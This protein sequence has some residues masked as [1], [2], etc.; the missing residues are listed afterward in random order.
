[1]TLPIDPLRTML[2]R[3]LE[4]IKREIEAYP[5]DESVWAMPA[6]I[7][8]SA[9]SLARHG[10]GNMPHYN[11]KCL[12]AAAYVRN[13]DAEFAR[14]DVPRVELIAELDRALSAIRDTL[15]TIE[16]RSVPGVFPDT[17]AGRTFD[18]DMF[19]LHLVAHLGYHVGQIDYHRRIT[20]GNGATVNAVGVNLMPERS[21]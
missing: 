3:E 11:G 17:I 6:G 20:T 8:N 13:R 18:S 10:A 12:G 9:G 19:L 4:S 5:S 2:E 1:M 15:D 21:A 16:A 7:A 14:R